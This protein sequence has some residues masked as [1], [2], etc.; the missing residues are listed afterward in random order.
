MKYLFSILLLVQVSVIAFGQETWSK[1]RVFTEN[2]NLNELAALGIDITE[3]TFKKGVYFESDFSSAQLAKIEVAGFRYQIL[4]DDVSSWYRERNEGKSFNVADYFKGTTQWP[5][6]ENFQLGSMGGHA[7]FDEAVAALDE[8]H[9]LYPDLISQKQSIGQSIE[10]REIW[11]VKIS[12]HPG[13]Q[14]DEPE[15]LYTAIHHAREPAG[16][17]NLLYYMWYLLENYESDPLIQQIVDTTQLYFVPVVNP[18][19][20]V[21]NQTTN[22]GGGGMWRKNRRNNSGTSCMGVDINRNYGYMWGLDNNGSSPDPCDE[23]YRGEAAFSEPETAAIR[24]FVEAHEFVNA[25]NYHTYSNLLLY[26]WGYTPDPSPDDDLFY[27]HSQLY[28]QDNHYTFGPGSTTIYPTNGGSD[29]WM[30]G[31]QSTKPKILAYTPELGGSDDGFW[32]PVDRIVPIAQ[33]NMIQN[34]LA[35]LFAGQY[36]SVQDLSPTVNPSVSSAVDFSF[37]RLGLKDGGTYSVSLIPASGWVTSTGAPV[38][39]NNPGLLDEESGSIS[40]ELDPAIPQGTAYQLV[41]QVD[42]G[43]FIF[44]DTLNKVFGTLQTLFEDDATTLDNWTPGNWGITSQNYVSPPSSITDSPNGDYGNN[45]INV[46]QLNEGIDLANAVYAQLT[47]NARWEIEQGWDYVQLLVSAD[48]GSWTPLAGQYTV[49]GNGNQAPGQPLYDGFQT[50]WVTESIDLS[51]FIGMQVKFR[52]LLK[53][54][55]WVTEDG[56]YF[57]DFTV[58]IIQPGT[59]DISAEPSHQF[60]VWPNPADRT[61]QVEFYEPLSGTLELYNSQGERFYRTYVSDTPRQRIDIS[62]LPEGVWFVRLITGDGTVIPKKIVIQH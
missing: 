47:F 15:V 34:I 54:D 33:E 41:L 45:Q 13:V 19:G 12:D 57:D 5:V 37:K 3:G 8:M 40:Y 20:Y 28:T 49:T 32:C 42:N 17:M 52:F 23:D 51:Q 6:P 38:I 59:T 39:F 48:N 10:G 30:Y 7:T 62:S 55:G 50:E 44:N 11:M 24:D 21:Y 9:T 60:A 18:D 35:A 46:C 36:A 29:D 26:A 25:L 2:H 27:A 16:L 4:V 61:L 58:Q 43:S 53:S 31:E 14:E 1:A 56:F 22:P